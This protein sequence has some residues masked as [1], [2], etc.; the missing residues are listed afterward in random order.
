ML[1]KTGTKAVEEICSYVGKSVAKGLTLCAI[2][3]V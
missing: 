2:D 3:A 1:L